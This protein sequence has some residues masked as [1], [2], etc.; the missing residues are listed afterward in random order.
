MRLNRPWLLVAALCAPLLASA[1]DLLEVYAQARA[2]DPQ[3]A[4]AAAQ[5]GE[6]GERVTQARAA[7]LP[8]WSLGAAELRGPQNGSRE[9]QLSSS[10]SQV[11]VDLSRLRQ[12]DAAQSLLSAEEARLRAA[13]QALCARV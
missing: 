6:Q 11:L 9:H 2:S 10:L 12:W 5:R 1:E 4:I 7:L 13:E 3:L 8:Q